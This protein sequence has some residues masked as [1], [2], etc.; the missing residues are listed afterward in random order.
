MNETG[1]KF[2]I[3][4]KTFLMSKKFLA[5]L[6]ITAVLSGHAFFIIW[7]IADVS[8]IG[9]WPASLLMVNIACISFVGLA[10]NVTQAKLDSAVRLAQ[11][12]G[13]KFDFKSLPSSI[14][15]TI[16]R[17]VPPQKDVQPGEEG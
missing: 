15:K 17:V 8:A 4:E 1:D 9:M 10:F 11:V 7:K 5:F 14:Q 13:G 6:V 2:K 3:F 12:F 16:G